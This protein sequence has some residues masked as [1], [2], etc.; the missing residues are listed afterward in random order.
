MSIIFFGLCFIVT[1]MN[2]HMVLAPAFLLRSNVPLNLLAITGE[3][4]FTGM[5]FF[6]FDLSL[7]ASYSFALVISYNR[8]GDGLGFRVWS[9]ILEMLEYFVAFLLRF[10]L[11]LSQV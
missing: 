9:S 3:L 4:L 7:F 1:C 8:L 6:N 10:C 5:Q 2:L 11:L